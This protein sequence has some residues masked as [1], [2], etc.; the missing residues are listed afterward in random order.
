MIN[1]GAT[2]IMYFPALKSILR[3]AGF[4][5][6]LFR[7]LAFFLL[8]SLIDCLVEFP[9][10]PSEM[11]PGCRRAGINRAVL[12]FGIYYLIVFIIHNKR[13]KIKIL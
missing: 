3:R 13:F 4:F 2:F 11:F 7:L 10:V 8:F 6:E 9:H 5:P 1:D 12:F